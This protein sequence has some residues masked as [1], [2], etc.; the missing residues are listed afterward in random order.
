VRIESALGIEAPA[1]REAHVT[2][3]VV[4]HN[5][6]DLLERCLTCLKAAGSV[7]PATIVVDNASSD[8]S[9]ELVGERFPQVRLIKCE[10]NVGFARANNIAFANTC[11]A[12]YVLLVNS[13]AFLAPGA[14]DELLDCAARHPD[15]GVVGPRLLNGDGTLQRSAWPFPSAG[16]LLLEA[17]GLHRVL[18]RVGLLED[19]GTWDH[20]SE[21]AVDFLIGAC[22]LLRGEALAEVR[23]FDE[24]FW[25][26]GEE[27]DLQRRLATRGW[28]TVLAPAATAVHVGGASSQ[29]EAPRR[30]TFYAGQQLFLEKHGARHSW[31]VARLALF[32]GSVLRR[33]WNTARL[34]LRW[35]S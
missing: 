16:R 25:L 20:G 9:A 24:S 3:V 12:E 23:G 4:S 14:L 35:N 11:A 1:E 30:R 34:A 8:G 26:Y 28:T 22:L 19:L 18:R 7:A 15:A 2:A 27:A 29:A 32:I 21:R 10:Q 31:P 33:R 17:F 13:D 5:T 6:R